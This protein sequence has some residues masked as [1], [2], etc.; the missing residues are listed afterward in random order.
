MRPPVA[1]TPRA[2]ARCS[3]STDATTGYDLFMAAEND[4][5]LA[6]LSR[7]LYVATTRAADYLIL[8]AGVEE[9]G[10]ATGPW[11]ELLA[12][13]FDLTTGSTS[14]NGGRQHEAA[15]AGRASP[16]RDR[17]SRLVPAAHGQGYRPSR[18][19]IRS[20]SISGGG[21]I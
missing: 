20:P 13:R 10:E 18:R 11:M 21:A 17:R 2:R 1:F 5:D 15:T 7:L 3:R 8:S 16:R 19:F 9:P 12:R 14:R 4:E 6:E